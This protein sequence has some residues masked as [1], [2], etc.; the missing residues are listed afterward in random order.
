MPTLPLHPA[1]VHVP[2]GLAFVLPL[3]TAAIALA[4]WRRRLPRAAF[5]VVVGLQAVLVSSGVVAMQLGERDE[6]RVERVV[7]ERLVEV[8]EDRAEAFLW[9]AG[10]VLAAAA[11]A[12]VLPG[13]AA[14]VASALTVAGTVAVLALAIR[15]GEAG[16]ALVYRDGAAAAWTAPAGSSR[17]PAALVPAARRGRDDD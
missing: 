9:A 12:L 14:G 1:A 15:T 4:V 10:L 17:G 2:L 13:A 16:G 11:A 3:V 6:D 7:A 8:H 5:A